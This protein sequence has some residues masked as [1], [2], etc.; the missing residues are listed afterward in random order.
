MSSP[1]TIRLA[2]S[3]DSDDAFM[4]WALSAGRIDTGDLASEHVLRDIETLY[5]EAE[6]G[7]YEVTALSFHAWAH[8]ADRYLLLPH[9][10]S[11][12]DGYGPILVARRGFREADLA[13]ATVAIPGERTTAALALRLWRPGLRTTVLPFDRIQPAVAS[14]EVPAGLLIHEGQ[15]T[16]ADEGLASLVDLGAWWKADT[17]LPLPLGGNGI[18]RDLD[19]GLRARVSR[20]LRASIA[21]G[22]EHRAEGLA[23]AA[24]FARGLPPAKTDRFVSMY[25]N[26]W[27]L[28]YG[29]AGR[30]AVRQFLQRGVDAGVIAKPVAIEFV[31]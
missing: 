22:L 19:P 14:G 23:H 31:D 7:T 13:A 9:G 6:K 2:H 11:F 10:A 5:R 3:P 28:D 1:A 21:F 12:G 8:L 24:R 4:F 25:V 17:G 26:D 29:E 20:H 18:R 30:R 15:L 16:F 27:T